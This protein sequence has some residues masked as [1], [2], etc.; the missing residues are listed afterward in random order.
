M[1][2]DRLEVARLG[3][4]N[5]KN[6]QG[7][8]LM[9]LLAAMV[10][11]LI[12]TASVWSL[13]E[14][15]RK[16]RTTTSERTE[17]MKTI[18]AGFTQIGR[19]AFNAGYAYPVTTPV[20]LPDNK[21]SGLIGVPND[22]DTTRDTVPPVIA[23]RQIT[24]NSFTGNKTDQVTFFYNDQTYNQDGSGVSQ[25]LS[26]SAPTIA[27]GA[28]TYDSVTTS[29]STSGLKVNDIVLLTGNTSN[30]IAVITNLVAGSPNSIRFGTGDVLGVNTPGTG[31]GNPLVNIT[32][33]CTLRRVVMVTYRVKSDGTLVRTVHGNDATVTVAAPSKDQPLVYNVEDMSVE[34]VLDNGTVSVNPT[35]GT[36]NTVGTADDIPSNSY[37]VRQVRVTLTVRSNQKDQK[38]Q[39]Y[40]LTMSSIFNTRNLGY[41]AA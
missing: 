34:Y 29:S 6:Q 37:K 35:A 41:S 16:S 20:L 40:K 2:K 25:P 39:P 7:F 5:N 13:M 19:D 8:S 17:L 11:F 36:D 14:I 4:A 26:I 27:A 3:V 22:F 15:T 1:Q 32:G 23:G 30:A 21:I 38:N 18:R 33:S 9:E 10:I 12:V 28:T 31:S 24:T